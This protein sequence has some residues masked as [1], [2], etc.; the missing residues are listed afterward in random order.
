MEKCYNTIKN[1]HM[2]KNKKLTFLWHKRWTTEILAWYSE[3]NMDQLMR[4]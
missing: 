2:F 3:H 1:K 4:S